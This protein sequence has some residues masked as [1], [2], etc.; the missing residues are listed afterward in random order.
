[1]CGAVVS[2]GAQIPDQFKNL[3]VLPKEL[4]RNEVT[5]RMR[6]IAMSLG[7]RCEFCHVQ[8]IGPDGREVTDHAAD[9]KETKKIAREMMKMVNDINDKYL[10]AGMGRT[11]TER[12]RVSCETCHHGLSKPRTLV[13]ALAEAV[14]AGGADSAVTLYR[15]LRNRYYGRAAYDFGELTLTEAARM[16]NQRP[17]NIAL[18]KLN[19]EFYPQSVPTMGSLGQQLAQSGDTAAAIE[20]LTKAIALDTANRQLRGMLTRLKGGRP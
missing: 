6:L 9:D 2:A 15:D 13:A 14:E 1:V 5:A 8:T 4:T 12:Q 10:I 16:P 17:A 18:L 19:L 20:V 7:V 3:Q 11:L